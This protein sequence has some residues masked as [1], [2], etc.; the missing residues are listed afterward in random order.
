MSQT[1]LLK[2]AELNPG[3]A[4]KLSFILD[5]VVE[6]WRDADRSQISILD[7]GCGRGDMSIPLAQ[8]GYRVHGIDSFE[9]RISEARAKAPQHAR[10][11]VGDA[12]SIPTTS[13]YNVILCVEVLEHLTEP[14][15]L[16]DTITGLLK[17]EGM[18]I[19][20]VPNGWSLLE[21]IKRGKDWLKS[22][23]TGDRLLNLKRRLRPV[24]QMA[25]DNQH[26]GDNHQQYFTAG[27]ICDLVARHGF[28]VDDMKNS[29][30]LFSI[31]N[32][33]GLIN[34]Q[35]TH[36]RKF[37]DFDTRLA[38]SVPRWLAGGWYLKCSRFD[39]RH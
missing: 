19:L 3:G 29:G 37:D 5:S 7:I 25:L 28:V 15:Q 17:P 9:P 11:E 6:R 13:Q 20:T 27:A 23:P 10:F 4:G 14:A 2:T 32:P 39:Q 21:T 26:P 16:I 24:D 35:S 36:F 33:I 38:P 1:E 22:T 12:R 31:L 34:T 18:L 8:L 30:P